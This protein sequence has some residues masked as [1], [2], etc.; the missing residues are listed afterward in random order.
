MQVR[1]GVV[2]LVAA[3]KTQFYG[4]DNVVSWQVKCMDIHVTFF[5]KK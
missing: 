3:G 1:S 4:L 5:Q 2:A